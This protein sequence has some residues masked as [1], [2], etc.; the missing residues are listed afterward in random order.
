[1]QVRSTY[2][3]Y[4]YRSKKKDIPRNTWIIYLIIYIFAGCQA[5]LEFNISGHF[6]TVNL[7][8][9]LASFL[10]LEFQWQY[11]SSFCILIGI[12]IDTFSYGQFGIATVSLWLV[13]YMI[14]RIKRSFYVEYLSTEIFLLFLLIAGF[15][16]LI[17]V[18]RYISQ[19]TSEFVES[20]T[21]MVIYN[22]SLTMC[23]VPFIYPLLK[24]LFHG[25]K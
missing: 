10:V 14:D 17:T 25:K 12:I 13:G 3:Y 4:N 24:A 2:S 23:A 19:E 11:I 15:S 1:M 9:L 20:F 16:F 7:L 8:L 22:A 5:N 18:F 6:F 21:S